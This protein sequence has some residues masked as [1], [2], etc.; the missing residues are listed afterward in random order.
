MF[1]RVLG[2]WWLVI[3]LAFVAAAVGLGTFLPRVAVDASTNLLLDEHDPAL[4]YYSQSRL[5]WPSDD[6]FAIVCCRRADWFA[7]ESV[8]LLREL[9]TD[10]V[11]SQAG[12]DSDVVFLQFLPKFDRWRP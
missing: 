7:P 2:R 10:L 1:G 12:K 5:L 3:V 6:E 9:Q 11:P 8:A 4:T